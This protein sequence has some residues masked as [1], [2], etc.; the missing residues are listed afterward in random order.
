[1]HTYTC[2]RGRAHAYTYAHTYI[3]TYIHTQAHADVVLARMVSRVSV[4]TPIV[5]RD[6]DVS[7]QNDTNVS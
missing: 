7:W 1:M 3:H 6:L 2:T 4:V 5:A